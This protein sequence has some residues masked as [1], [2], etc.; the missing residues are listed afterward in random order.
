MGH[1]TGVMTEAMYYV[2]VALTRQNHG[3]GLKNQI[4]EMSGG[5]VKMGP[6][7]LYGVLKRL[8]QEHMILLVED[9]GRKKTYE[10]TQSGI[11]ALMAEY[12]RLKELTEIGKD[13]EGYFDKNRG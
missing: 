10:I 9:D 13:L 7:T 4:E 3:Y 12:S 2:L 1:E 6:G 8:S 11:T 5:R